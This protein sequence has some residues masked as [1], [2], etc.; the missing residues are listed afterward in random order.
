[1]SDTPKRTAQVERTL[2]VAAI[3]CAWISPDHDSAARELAKSMA[4][5]LCADVDRLRATLREAE[6]QI[7]Y[8]HEKF[9]ETGSGT[10]VLERIRRDLSE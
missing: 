9:R 8:L 6:S 3:E 10:A 7:E 5:R 4:R 1:M 2:L